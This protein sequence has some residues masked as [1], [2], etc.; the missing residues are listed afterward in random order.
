[1]TNPAGK[2]FLITY[3]K[4]L[5]FVLSKNGVEIMSGSGHLHKSYIY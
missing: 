4:K 1:M 2:F 5:I 3:P